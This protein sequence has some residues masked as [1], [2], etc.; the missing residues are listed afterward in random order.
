MRRSLPFAR[1]DGAWFQVLPGSWSVIRI[2]RKCFVKPAKAPADFRPNPT[3]CEHLHLIRQTPSE[4]VSTL[5][6]G[7]EAEPLLPQHLQLTEIK[8]FQAGKLCLYNGV[9]SER[10]FT[11]S[12]IR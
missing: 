6:F 1:E 5:V 11:Y 9:G 8:V 10:Q 4:K 2:C 3:V 7:N 12:T